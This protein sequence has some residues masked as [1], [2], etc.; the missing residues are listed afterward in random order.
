MLHFKD[1]PLSI[2]LDDGGHL[3]N[4]IYTI[5]PLFLSD[6]WGISEEIITGVYDLYKMIVNGIL[7]AINVNDSVTKNKLDNIYD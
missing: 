5:Y 7:N 3:T 6:I 4:F 2:I 1:E